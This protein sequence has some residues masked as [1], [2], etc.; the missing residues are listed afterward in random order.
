MVSSAGVRRPDRTIASSECPLDER[1][2]SGYPDAI[3][4]R[5]VAMTRVLIVDDHQVV[6][7][8]VAA[9]L[10][11][12]P[13]IEVVGCAGTVAGAIAAVKRESPDVVLMDFRLPDG[14]GADATAIIRRHHPPPAVVVLSADDGDRALQQAAESGACG[15]VV[16]SGGAGKIVDAVRRAV[17]GEMT[18]PTER[19]VQRLAR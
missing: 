11:N 4:A 14:T 18:F 10:D 2:S 1:S 19:P 9:I 17:R 16:K 12:H 7:E 6:C 3:D 5:R 13:D 15:Y 8:T